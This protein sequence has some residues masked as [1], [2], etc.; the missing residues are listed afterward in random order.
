MSYT[1]SLKY[2]YTKSTGTPWTLADLGSDAFA[3][4]DMNTGIT[5]AGSGKVSAWNDFLGNALRNLS[6]ATGGNRPTLTVDGVAFNGTSDYIFNT[7]PFM[8]NSA[9]GV[10]VMAIMSAPANTSSSARWSV[11]E[12]STASTIQNMT[13]LAKDNIVADYGKITQALRNDAN[14]NILTYGGNSGAGTAFDNTFKLLSVN[15]NKS[16][17]F[18]TTS[19]N[20]VVE[21]PPLA[22]T[23]SGVFTLNRFSLGAFVRSMVLNYSSMTI[24]GMAFLNATISTDDHQRSEGYLCHLYNRT[25]LLPVGHP[26]KTNPPLVG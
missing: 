24:K 8:A 21:S 1:P 17:G 5:D 25:D 6:Q 9:N 15:F 19:I 26:Y 16:T 20:G 12:G 7:N 18:I 14:V 13:L 10:T 4:Y 3:F 2:G 22:F 23:S 11:A